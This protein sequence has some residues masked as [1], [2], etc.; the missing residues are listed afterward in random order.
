MSDPTTILAPA[1]LPE[2]S[3]PSG[4]SPPQRGLGVLGVLVFSL[5]IAAAGGLSWLTADPS[6]AR[7]VRFDSR[8]AGL[9]RFVE[10]ERGLSFVRPV[11]VAFLSEEEYRVEAT[12]GEPQPATEDDGEA[13]AIS[14]VGRALGLLSGEVDL[15]AEGEELVGGGTLAY[16]DP[17]AKRI[18]VRGTEVTVALQGTLVHELTHAL[19]D[20]H[21]GVDRRFESDGA[22]AAFASL[23][24][25]DAMRMETA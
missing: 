17:A 16:Y 9:A 21:F 5:T 19:Q 15:E 6:P 22:Q 18:V 11:S 14:A 3:P 13:E 2:S 24:E 4:A 20:Q 1:P 7:A 12:S 25:G 8:V 23:I 10:T